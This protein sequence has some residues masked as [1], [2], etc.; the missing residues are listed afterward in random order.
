MKYIHF[1]DH[2][3]QLAATIAYEI[4][5]DQVYYGTVVVSDRQPLHE[6]NREE[7]RKRSHGR[8]LA[9]IKNNE[10]VD[11]KKYEW[12]LPDDAYA[13]DYQFEAV[14]LAGIYKIGIMPVDQFMKTT[15]KLKDAIALC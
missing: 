7:G 11:W 15:K 8:C 9:A 1:R 12:S 10:N 3:K 2:E 13:Y 6:I 5:E 4:K 14:K